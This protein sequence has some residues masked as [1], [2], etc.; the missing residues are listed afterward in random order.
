MHQSKDEK[1]ALFRQLIAAGCPVDVDPGPDELTITQ[2]GESYIM[3]MGNESVG[4][5]LHVALT[6]EL[7][8]QIIVKE[9]GDLFLPWGRM[10]AIWLDPL[11]KGSD[12]PYK[13]PKGFSFERDLVLND[14]LGA[15]G[16]RLRRGDYVSGLVLGYVRTR[17]SEKYNHGQLLDAKFSVFDV[18]GKEYRGDV[19][20]FMDREGSKMRRS[21]VRPGKGLFEPAEPAFE[22]TL[23]PTAR[24]RQ[25]PA[26]AR[27][28]RD[29]S[30][31][32]EKLPRN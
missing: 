6:R 7:P 23:K 5:V 19:R 15:S 29:D 24:P 20:F 12:V 25:K 2:D 11:E 8:G 32:E 22:S 21:A 3:D 18:T 10:P 13:L 28:E 27:T 26:I 31:V 17:I 16:M 30:A 4:I 1:R 9:F 14:K